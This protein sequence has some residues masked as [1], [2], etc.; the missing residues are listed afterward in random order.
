MSQ[1]ESLEASIAKHNQACETLH[2]QFTENHKST[3]Q[4]VS[5][6]ALETMELMEQ[7]SNAFSTLLGLVPALRGTEIALYDITRQ[8]LQ[9][10]KREI[11]TCV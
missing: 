11:I 8:L 3:C 7:P 2:E 5:R 1:Q 6:L 10:A 4:E 9:D